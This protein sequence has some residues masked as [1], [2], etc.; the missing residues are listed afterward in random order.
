MRKCILWGGVCLK[1]AHHSA[2]Y[3]ISPKRTGSTRHSPN[4]IMVY[5]APAV[6]YKLSE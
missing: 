1:T 3:G 6:H 2:V 4:D 5:P